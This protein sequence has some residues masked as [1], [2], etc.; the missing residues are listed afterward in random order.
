MESR[1]PKPSGLKKP[2][3]PIKTVLPT[4]RIRAGLGGG[5]AGAGAFNVNANQTYCGN[6]L[7]PLSRDLNNLPQVLERRGG[8]GE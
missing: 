6:L 2:Q 5:A 4:D 1:L 7:P 8:G 3:M